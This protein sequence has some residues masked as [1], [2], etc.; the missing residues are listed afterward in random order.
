MSGIPG[1]AQ[2][3][4][5]WTAP[6]SDGGAAITGYRIEVSSG[7]SWTVAV[8]DT[9]ATAT[10]RLMTGLTNGT[11]Y[12]F[13]VAA[14]NTAGVGP[15]SADSTPITPRTVP[16]APTGVSGIPGD[17]QVQ[18]SW[19]APGSDGGAA[20]TGYR[21]EVSSGGS[22]TVAVADTGATATSRLMTG[23]TN[24]TGYQFRVAA[25]NTAGVGPASADSTPMTPRTVPGAPT[26][27]SGIPGD[28]QVQLSW[29]A[30]GSDGGAAITGYRI[31]VSSG[32]SWTVAVADTGATAT[33]RLMTGLTNGTGYQFRVA[34]I[35]T[36]GVGPASEPS[37]ALPRPRRPPL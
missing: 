5:S 13:R 7:G 28:A 1:D 25:I 31:E 2:V 12:Q 35:N 18:L 24:G 10:S 29:T 37:A 6:G 19:T 30:P 34:A 32:G 36:A 15:A 17:A 20:I 14:I 8:A 27:V 4:L 3:Q 21:I 22:W 16:G 23:L 11:G 26:G 33:S 9:G